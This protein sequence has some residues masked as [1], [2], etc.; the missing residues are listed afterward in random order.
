VKLG[1]LSDHINVCVHNPPTLQ[2][3]RRTDRRTDDIL[4]IA[5][6]SVAR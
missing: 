5:T 3:E 4:H 6:L 1:L 2:T